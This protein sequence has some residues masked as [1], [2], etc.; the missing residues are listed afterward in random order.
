M[1]FALTGNSQRT[2]SG[3]GNSSVCTNLTSSTSRL[4]LD[5][6]STIKAAYLYWSGS[7]AIDSQVTFANTSVTAPASTIYTESVGNLT[8]YS[9]KA[10][11]TSLV[12]NSSRNYTVSNL[13]FNTGSDYCVGGRSYGGWALTVVY[14]NASEALRVINIFDGFRNF[15]GQS[16]DLAP[17]NFVIAQNPSTLG[18]KHAHITWEGDSGNSGQRNSLSESLKFNGTGTN[19]NNSFN[20][21]TGTGNPT[22][23]QFNSY[24]NVVSRTTDGVDIDEYSIGNYLTAGAT[25]VI[26]RY[27]S[28]QD[29]VFLT[30]EIISIPNEHVAELSIKQVGPTNIIRNLENSFEFTITNNGPNNAPNSTLVRIPL[31]TGFSMESFSGTQWT[32]A[33]NSGEINCNYSNDIAINASSSPLLLKLKPNNSA[34]NSVNISATVTGVEFDNI[35]SNNTESKTYSLISADLSSS[36]KTVI[37]INGGNVEAGD[38]LRYQIDIIESNGAAAAGITLVDHLPTNIS[39]FN[40]ISIPSGAINNSQAAPVG[41]NASGILSLSNISVSANATASIIFNATINNS[42]PDDTAIKNTATIGGSIS[43]EIEIESATVYISKTATPASGNKPLYIRQTSNLSRIQPTSTAYNSLTDLAEITYPISPSF[44]QEFKFSDSSVSAY[45]FLQNDYDSGGSWGHD[46]TVSLMLNNSSIGSINRSISVPS[47][48]S[49]GNN[50]AL[51]EFLIPLLSMPTINAGDTLALKVENDSEYTVDSLRIYSIDPN[52]SNSDAVSPYSL[53]SLP[54]ATVINVDEISILNGANS[55]LIT[56]AAPSNEVIIQAQVS[57]PFGSFDI[58]SANISIEDSQGATLINQQSMGILSDSGVATKT[59]Q[60]TYEIPTNAEL[61]DWKVSITALEGVE[62]DIEHTSQAILK[63]ATPLPEISV[64][65]SVEVYSDPVHGT[66]SAS[67]Y[68]KA[69]PGAILTYTVT[70]QNTGEGTA[71]DDSIWISDA[72]PDNTYMIVTD[73]DDVNGRGPVIDT[74]AG[75]LNG[76]TYEFIALNSTSDDIE[77]SNSEGANFNYSPT[78][79]SEGLDKNVTHFRINPKG[80]FQAPAAGETSKQFTIKFRVQLQ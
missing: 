47:R 37:D 65:K 78:E 59:F 19:S 8:F 53:V 56:E 14:S 45:I 67:S 17:N 33:I 29:R 52:P 46:V 23:N 21:L 30:A 13:T 70:A 7:G 77:F 55:Q 50:V 64:F 79:D 40:I 18:G 36:I 44:Q 10:D 15:W 41:N 20:D 24:S 34:S 63:I 32:C 48:T 1:S 3:S 75:T 9:A 60:F 31:P 69:F 6:N 61:G 66:N 43:S 4:N 16:F 51:F 71:L 35:L 62:N 57:D 68:A 28:G 80:I 11:V 54:A 73:Y 38:I 49:T 58:T 42:T 2:T 76:L 5:N 39:S 22:S 12:S 72:V 27:S 74:T 26:T 25:S